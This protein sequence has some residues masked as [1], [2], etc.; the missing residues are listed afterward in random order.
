MS[1][2]SGGG[3]S[4]GSSGKSR[5]SGGKGQ[6]ITKSKEMKTTKAGADQIVY[7]RGAIYDENGQ[8]RN[9]LEPLSAFTSLRLAAT[10]TTEEEQ[11]TI[12]FATGKQVPRPDLRFMFNLSKEN[13][14]DIYNES[15]YGWDDDDK[16]SELKDAA[17]RHLLVRTASGELVG[18]VSFQMTLQG[19]MYEKPIGLACVFVREMQVVEKYR[20][21]GIGRHLGR[22]MEMIGMKH[23]LSYVEYLVTSA[24]T[25]AHDFISQKLKGYSTEGR[26]DLLMELDGDWDDDSF[27][28]YSKVVS[29]ELK[30]A[31]RLAAKRAKEGQQL[32][33]QLAAAMKAGVQLT[34]DSSGKLTGTPAK[35][36]TETEQTASPTSI[37][38]T[39]AQSTKN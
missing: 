1:K 37:L 11:L 39:A 5:S 35:T 7:L 21:R 14:E 20:R 9:V 31:A 33:N 13:M 3:S 28:I 38:D 2:S 17:T 19:E 25:A 15:E 29:R 16:R 27:V 12:S 32:A 34:T 30:M 8:D 18:F 22:L 23:Q 36:L 4:R 24:N 10:D 26:E 6:A